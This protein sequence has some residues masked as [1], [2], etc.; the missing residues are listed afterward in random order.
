MT[1]A[2]QPEPTDRKIKAEVALIIVDAKVMQDFNRD[3]RKIDKSTNV[4][5][6]PANLAALDGI[7]HLGDI[8]ACA[9]VINNEASE[10]AKSIEAHWAH[11]MIHGMLHLQNHD[12]NN[13][14]E[15][16]I[17]ETLEINFL[18]QLGFANPY[19]PT[20]SQI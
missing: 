14:S 13:D 1:I 7:K 2:Y 16:L 6:F 9:S 4:L 17:M 10:Q 20:H 11:M 8:I 15:A 5:S 12:H 3:Y 19:T 18:K